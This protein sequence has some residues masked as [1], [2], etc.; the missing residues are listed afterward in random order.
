MRQNE[1]EGTKHLKLE[2]EE[3]RTTWN[4]KDALL[5]SLLLFATSILSRAPIES[6]R[7]SSPFTSKVANG[8]FFFL[9][10]QEKETLFVKHLCI[11]KYL[12]F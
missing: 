2:E 9:K 8:I 5:F 6:T 4:N 3:V 7:K 12:C 1:T 11:F 10:K